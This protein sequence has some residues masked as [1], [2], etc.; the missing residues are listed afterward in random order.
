MIG[1]DINYIREINPA[2]LWRD[3]VWPHRLARSRTY[4]SQPS[5]TGSNPVGATKIIK[6][7]LQKCGF[8]IFAWY[9]NG[10]WTKR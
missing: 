1:G 2:A 7:A 6:A 3:L 5:N 4:G 9:P 8:F 10:I